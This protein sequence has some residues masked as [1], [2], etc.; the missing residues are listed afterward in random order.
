M[1]AIASYHGA[2][3]ARD[4]E[5]SIDDRTWRDLDLDDVY[6]LLDRTVSSIGQQVL[7]HRLRSLKSTST[8]RAFEALVARAAADASLRETCQLALARLHGAAGCEVWRLAEPGAVERRSWHIVSPVLALAML[9]AAG[10]GMWWPAAF[11]VNL[12]LLPACIA[13]RVVNERRLRRVIEPL[14]LVG[15]LVAAAAVVWPIHDAATADISARLREDADCLRRLRALADWLARDS[16]S[17]DPITGA[18]FELLNFLLALDGNA[19]FFGSREIQA[20]APA[21]QRTIAAVGEVDAAIA[22]AAYRASSDAWTRP[23]FESPGAPVCITELGHPLLPSGV[24]NSVS[25][26]PPHGVLITGSNM[27]GKSTFL[28]SLGVAAIMSQTIN[29]CTASAYACPPLRVRS[30]MNRSDDLV[31]GR[32]YYLDEVHGILAIVRASRS[33]DAHLF[34]FDELFQG[35]NAVERL[36][37]GEATLAELADSKTPHVTVAATHDVELVA[38]LTPAYTAFHFSD[39][40]SSGELVFDYRLAS[41]PSSTRNAISLLELNGAPASLVER[42]R[43][44]AERL[45][46]EQPI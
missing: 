9:G 5:S 25:L 16:V 35:T 31:G 21:L 28:R 6:A 3:A 32:S 1:T 23:S 39:H 43:A 36:A 14:R 11:L 34:L 13:V 40:V 45:E 15:P 42:A 29:T 22:I 8:L 18:A 27:S 37:A 33:P 7:Y 30:C 26:A 38:L 17:M 41:G 2:F 20:H 10:A 4:P 46:R 44:L 24:R 12:G 19:L